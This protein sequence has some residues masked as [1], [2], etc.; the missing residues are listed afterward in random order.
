M[1]E[2]FG[3]AVNPVGLCVPL[4]KSQ[5]EGNG[6]IIPASTRAMRNRHVVLYDLIDPSKHIAQNDLGGHLTLGFDI[7]N[8]DYPGIHV[9]IASNGLRGL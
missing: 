6:P 9:H 5:Q 2:E 1:A 8:L 7:H 3:R 4:P